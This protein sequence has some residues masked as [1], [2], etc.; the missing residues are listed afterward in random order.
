MNENSHIK[1]KQWLDQS[2]GAA[3]L[4]DGEE[5]AFTILEKISGEEIV[6]FEQKK[7]N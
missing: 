2:Q 3:L 5:Y 7:Q 1:L 6:D 4:I